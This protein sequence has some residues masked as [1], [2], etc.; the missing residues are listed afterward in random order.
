MILSSMLYIIV[1]IVVGE[2]DKK[3]GCSTGVRPG[4][5]IKLASSIISQ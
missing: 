2:L 1:L 5:I 4:R 3:E